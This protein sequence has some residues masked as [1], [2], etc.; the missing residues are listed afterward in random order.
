[1]NLHFLTSRITP[2]YLLM[3]IAFSILIACGGS[4]NSGKAS[5]VGTTLSKS[6]LSTIT[7]PAGS[8]CA[9]GGLKISAGRDLNQNGVLDANEPDYLA[10]LCNGMVSP[11]NINLGI[12]TLVQFSEE[13]AGANCPLGGKKLIVGQDINKNGVVDSNELPSIS[14]ACYKS[15]GTYWIAEGNPL[16]SRIEN[17]LVS[18]DGTKL[19]A[20]FVLKESTN[21]IQT[22]TPESNQIYT[23]T[24]SGV[25]WAARESLRTWQSIVMSG[26]AHT[27]FA[28]AVVS[29]GPR[30]P[31]QIPAI[32][33]TQLYKSIDGGID[34]APLSAPA[35]VTVPVHISLDGK[36]LVVSGPAVA[37]AQGGYTNELFKSVDGGATWTS[38]GTS[39]PTVFSVSLPSMAFSDDASKIV[40]ATYFDLNFGP[41]L[42]YT[43]SDS[44]LTWTPRETNRFW[45][46]VASSSDGAKLVAVDGNGEGA[47]GGYGGLIYTSSDS[48][49]T[50]TPRET[51]RFWGNVASSSDGTKLVTL[52]TRQGKLYTSSDSGVTWM[53]REQNRSWVQVS[54]S[55][56]GSTQYALERSTYFIP[57][58][59]TYQYQ[60]Y[61]SLNAL[62]S[63]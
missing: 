11:Q 17:L 26:D 3:I 25:T 47:T 56:D 55:A 54:S 59:S 19:A 46:S 12:Y 45:V 2:L 10:Y 33:Q 41:G 21:A 1:M 43:S 32:T 7:E 29:Y 4:S 31:G 22:Y 63:Y 44:G 48:G 35:A 37:A 61:S 40:Y 27:L 6:A 20:I 38:S 9:N 49:V 28:S 30:G 53:P 39:P 23:S 52:D 8:N 15:L 13:P 24:D 62:P 50:W 14:Y 16:T 5:T 42:M 34:W 51:N 57:G 36:T 60:L 18:M 58:T